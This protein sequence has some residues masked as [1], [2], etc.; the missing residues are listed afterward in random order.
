L[1]VKRI[2]IEALHWRHIKS[3][4]WRWP[5]FSPREMAD[6]TTGQ[7]KVAIDLMDQL[8]DLRGAIGA[9]MQITSGY[10]SPEHNLAVEG[11][12][13]SK[14]LL[15]E[16]VDVSMVGHDPNA[17]YEMAQDAGFLGFG[18]YPGQRFMHIDLGPKR[19]W[20]DPKPWGIDLSRVKRALIS[21][22]AGGSLTGAGFAGQIGL[23]ALPDPDAVATAGDALTVAGYNMQPLLDI[24]PALKIA[25]ALLIVAGIGLTVWAQLRRSGGKRR[26]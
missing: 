25:F 5:H 24:L 19:W 20:G 9:P 4:D 3:E 10:R 21:R 7:I 2:Y 11:K 15:G 8:E 23:D 18:F 16:A 26:R 14:H 6:T 17:F 1:I 12:K 13:G 22:S